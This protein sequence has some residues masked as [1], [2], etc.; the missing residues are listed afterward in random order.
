MRQIGIML[1]TAAPDARPETVLEYGRRAE[2][3]GV[4]ALWLLDRLVFDNAEPLVSL[5]ALAAATTRVRLGTSVLLGALRPPPLLAKMLATLDMLSGG[6]LVLGLGVGSRPDDFAAAG[7]PFARRGGRLA[8]LIAI[9]RLAWS[10][11]PLRYQG[12]HYQLDVGPV[13]PRPVQAGGPP[14]WI[15]G[16]AEP[17]LR[18]V[19]RL[20]DGYI[21]TSSGG[22]E[23]VRAAW[24]RVRQHAAA[25]GRDPAALTLGALV[26]AAVDNDHDRA[27]ERAGRFLRHY[28]PPARAQV[29]PALLLGPP[30]ACIQRAEEYFAAG[31]QMLIIGPVTADPDHFDRLLSEVVARLL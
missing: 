23:G 11:A 1:P 7:V 5:G 10:G 26:W 21:G 6:R 4:H 31:V 2:A 9:L 18:R 28:Y 3:A 15:G 27:V 20:A 14:I 17:A 25:A 24:A 22:P 16:S 12:R 13:G 29:S 19:G 8:E 30:A